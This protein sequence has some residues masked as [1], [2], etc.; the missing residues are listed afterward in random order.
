MD[1]SRIVWV[2]RE[3]LWEEGAS[4]APATETVSVN[5]PTP[6]ATQGGMTGGSASNQRNSQRE[7]WLER[8]LSEKEI[9]TPLLMGNA[10]RG[11]V[12]IW[13]FANS[14]ISA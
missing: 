12:I 3:F 13:S 5:V 10:D 14:N 4:V 1:F 6:S 11:N 8:L 2:R 9:R 7:Y